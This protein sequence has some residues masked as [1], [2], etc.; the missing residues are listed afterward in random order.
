MGYRGHDYK[1]QSQVHV[2]KRRRGR[3]TK[4]MWRWMKRRAAIEPGAGHLKREYRMD[5]NQLKGK[6][7]DCVNAILSAAGMN[8][9]RLLKWLAANFLCP[10]FTR[11]FN[12][13]RSLLVMNLS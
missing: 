1:G 8:F 5:R 12:F 11:L 3:T 13:Q 6:Q 7:G 9:A 4:S 2:D 10:I